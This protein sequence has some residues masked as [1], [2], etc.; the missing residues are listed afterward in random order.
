MNSDLA[1]RLELFRGRCP[2]VQ[3]TPP[4]YSGV[5]WRA[6]WLVPA[7]QGGAE[8]VT[9]QNGG[10]LLDWLDVRFPAF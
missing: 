1:Q 5:R 10:M 8:E 3:V 6:S 9:R 4:R 2:W 7:E